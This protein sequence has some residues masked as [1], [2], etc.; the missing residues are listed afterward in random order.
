VTVFVSARGKVVGEY[1][2][3][4]TTMTL[5]HYLSSLFHVHV[6]AA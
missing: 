3:A 1:L 6:P 2:G 5:T 4:L